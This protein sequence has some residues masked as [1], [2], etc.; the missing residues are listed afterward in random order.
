MIYL[1]G[2][3]HAHETIEDTKRY[4][5]NTQ[6]E[7]VE[8]GYLG[9]ENKD[10]KL[11]QFIPNVATAVRENVGSNGILICGTG[12]GVEIGANRFAGI[13][14]S[15]C[16]SARSAEWARIYDNANVLCIASWAKDEINLV[17]ILDAWF[18]SEYDGSENRLQMFAAFDS[19]VT[20][21]IK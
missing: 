4:L 1:G 14:A 10:A 17:E 15:L 16:Y 18:S 8:F 11:Q 3:H 20:G 21:E 6:R 19:W 12:A 7:Y 9:G 2:D 13:R 5:L